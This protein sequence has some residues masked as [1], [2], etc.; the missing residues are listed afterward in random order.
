MKLH[1]LI[2]SVIFIQLFSQA[3]SEFPQATTKL[4]CRDEGGNLIDWFY[5]YKLPNT[6]DNDGEVHRTVIHGLSYM[7]VTPTSNSKWI[8]SR[9]LINESTSMPGMTLAEIYNNGDDDNLVIMYNDDPPN[10]KS[11]GARGHTK[12]V[13][14]ANEFGGFW[15]IHS[16]PNFPPDVSDGAYNYPS[17]ANLYG[18]SF[19][20]ISMNTAQLRKVGKQL[21]FNEPHFFSSSIPDHLQT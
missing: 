18:Q 9:Q 13:V 8:Y 4:G 1:N 21:Q 19:L 7:F 15:L 3:I 12:G 20:C 10:E 2:F 17:T 14:V 11:D 16:V 6:F 5:L